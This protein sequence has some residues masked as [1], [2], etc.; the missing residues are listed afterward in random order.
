MESTLQGEKIAEAIAIDDRVIAGNRIAKIA[1]TAITQKWHYVAHQ[2]DKMVFSVSENRPIDS[3]I[4]IPI[5]VVDV[6]S[7]IAFIQFFIHPDFPLRKGEIVRTFTSDGTKIY[8]QVTLANI[9]EQNT[10]EG[11]TLK[12]VLVTAGQLG[13]WQETELRF[14]QFAWIPP[15]GHLIHHI[16][17]KEAQD[18]IV[19]ETKAKVGT[20]PNSAFPVF[21]KVDDLVTHNTAVIGVTGSGKSYLAFHLLESFIHK[22]IKVLVLDLTREHFIYLQKFNPT[23]LKTVA[24][25]ENWYK[26]ESLLGIHQF[27]NS[28]SYPRTT[29]D[30]AKAVFDI[31]SSE[32]L[33]AGVTIPARLC[34]VFEEAHSLIPEW[35]QVADKNDINHVNATARTILQGRKFGMGSLIITQRTA[36]VTKTILN[37]CNTMIAMRSFD[38]TGLDFLSNYMGKEYSQA[39][40]TLPTRDAIIVGKASS[41]QTPVIFT[42]PD[43]STRWKDDDIL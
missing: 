9:I 8:Y 21:A 3:D 5:S 18:L 27:A 40:S 23:P 26:S 29:R 17:K 37:Q 33:Q 4:D 12:N 19:P 11:N 7:N 38:Q 1:M 34:L 22:G 6:G 2:P 13:V 30:F 25:V 24:D 35:N 41:C 16:T 36:N 20:I 42:I 14:E 15:A 10:L 43:F 31:L 32:P 39:V 28:N